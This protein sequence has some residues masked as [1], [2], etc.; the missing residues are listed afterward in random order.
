[1]HEQTPQQADSEPVDIFNRPSWL[2]SEHPFT[3]AVSVTS[4]GASRN[5]EAW[6]ERR[7]NLAG[8]MGR[9]Y[10]QLDR[11]DLDQARIRGELTDG[12]KAEMAQAARENNANFIRSNGYEP[13][14]TY[15]MWPQSTYLEK[16]GII[17]LDDET[18]LEVDPDCGLATMQ[19]KQGDFIYTRDP[20]KVLGCRPADCP[21]L[22]I[23]STD[24]DG[25]DVFA[26][27]HVGWQ[28]LNA[29]Y[30]EQAM[31][32][33]R[34]EGVD[35]STLRIYVGPGSKK[36]NY[37][38]SNEHNPLGDESPRFT[39]PDREKLFVDV[40]KNE[41]TGKYDFAMDMFAFIDYELTDPERLGLDPW[42]VAYDGSDTADF[43]SGYSSHSRVRQTDEINTRSLVIASMSEPDSRKALE[44]TLHRQQEV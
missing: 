19:P 34:T 27:L 21:V 10:A 5:N 15:V 31:G 43:D 4:V 16:L 22:V 20:E 35:F 30:L 2:D 9:G 40:V 32:F 42:Q 39:H 3:V 41:E 37:P 11:P 33:L 18:M 14:N 36:E 28:G 26:M 23:R 44:F 17:N 8:N 24:M 7:T 6:E 38:Y 13:E 12:Q 1:M 25:Q 29:G